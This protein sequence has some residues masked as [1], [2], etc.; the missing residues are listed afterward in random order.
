MSATAYHPEPVRI[1]PDVDPFRG[2]TYRLQLDDPADIDELEGDE[3]HLMCVKD[4]GD[5]PDVPF[6]FRLTT[7]AARLLAER[8][9]ATCEERDALSARAAGSS[10]TRRRS[11]PGASRLSGDGEATERGGLEV[12]RRR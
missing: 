12:P 1:T 8:L 5:G 11:R 9:V 4:S 10:A 2:G 6:C 3:I 7:G